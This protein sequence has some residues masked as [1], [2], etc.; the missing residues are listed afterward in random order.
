MIMG[1]MDY[2]Y[3][4]EKFKIGSL[5]IG[6]ILDR[7]GDEQDARFVVMREAT[8]QEYLDYCAEQNCTIKNYDELDRAKFFLISID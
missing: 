1:V 6:K 5:V 8:R 3:T 2:D 7:N 4:P